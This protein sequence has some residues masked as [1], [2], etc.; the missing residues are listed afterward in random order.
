MNA[1]TLLKIDSLVKRFGGVTATN[2]L[3]LEIER[4]GV[5][6]LIGPN[7]AGKSTLFKL[8]IGLERPTSGTIWY[9]D[10]NI[11][12]WEPFR[13]ARAG[14]AVKFQDLRI[15]PQLS[16]LQ[17][18]FLPLRRAS[19]ATIDMGVVEAL[20]VNYGLPRDP[21]TNAGSLSHGQKQWL[22][23]AMCVAANPDLVLLDEPTAGMGVQETEETAAI[24]RRMGAA[25]TTVVVIE[26]DMAFVRALD[27]RTSVLHQGRLFAQGSLTEIE[28]RHDV[29]DIYLGNTTREAAS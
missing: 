29:R 19:G 2:D 10:Q 25:G 16:L 3:T 24:V 5:H 23:L 21:H 13:R 6:C 18:L 9:K 4:G 22:A 28:S 27:T 26:H 11:T 20:L 14:I 17:N 8:L 15:F 12:R 1:G 7:G